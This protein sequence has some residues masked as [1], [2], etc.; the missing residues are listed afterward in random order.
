MQ[1]KAIRTKVFS[2]GMDLVDFI[3]ESVGDKWKEQSILAITSKIVSLAESRTIS[4]TKLGKKELIQQECE[5]YLGEIGY[6][7][8]LAIRHGLLVPSAG[9]DESN[10]AKDEYILYPK[11]P[12]SSLEQIAGKIK[13]K[14]PFKKIGLMMTDS[15]TLPLR[16]GVVGVALAYSGF[17]AVKDMVGQKDLFGRSLRMTKINIV[18][19]LAASAVLLMGEGAGQCPLALIYEAPVTFV[20]NTDPSELKISIEEDLYKPLY[21]DKLLPRE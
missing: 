18:D 10:S 15:R 14:L 8:H 19:A 3:M 13:K 4:K 1:I 9:I 11:D 7:C 17:R 5:H 2:P 6:D 21:I 20:E 16:Q 12:F